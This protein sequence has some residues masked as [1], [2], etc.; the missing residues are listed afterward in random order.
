MMRRS[1]R[2]KTS[3]AWSGWVMGRLFCSPPT[4]RQES[5]RVLVLP[6]DGGVGGLG[7]WRSLEKEAEVGRDERVGRRHRVGV[8]DGRVLSRESD[9]ARVLAQT[10][11][12]LTPDLA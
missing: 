1:S 6:P 9:P 4:K 11:L 12:Q 8:V 5:V 2:V 10:V 7:F 3:G